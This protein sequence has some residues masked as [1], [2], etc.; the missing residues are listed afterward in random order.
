MDACTSIK[1]GEGEAASGEVKVCGWCWRLCGHPAES[2]VLLAELDW[3]F[4]RWMSKILEVK[5]R[6][7]SQTSVGSDSRAVNGAGGRTEQI[8]PFRL[9]QG[10]LLK[11]TASCLFFFI[12]NAGS[13][14]WNFISEVLLIHRDKLQCSL[15]FA[16]K[17]QLILIFPSRLYLHR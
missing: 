9:L 17:K 8:P 7:A 6:T 5:N 3:S 13:Y 14:C 11:L 2:H 12:L 1:A 4:S 15:V 16:Q 10:Q